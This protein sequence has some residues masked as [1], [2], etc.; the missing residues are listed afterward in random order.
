MV[1]GFWAESATVNARSQNFSP[2]RRTKKSVLLAGRRTEIGQQQ[3][4]E[5][6][7]SFKALQQFNWGRYKQICIPQSCALPSST[8]PAFGC[9]IS[10]NFFFFFSTT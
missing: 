5:A 2:M 4:L 1:L 8:N 7:F 10:I 9:Y 3:E 6:A